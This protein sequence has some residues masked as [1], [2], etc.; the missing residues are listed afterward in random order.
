MVILTT[1]AVT[2][3]IDRWSGK[4]SRLYHLSRWN[5]LCQMTYPLLS[6][7]VM[8]VKAFFFSLSKFE[9]LTTNPGRAPNNQNPNESEE[10]LIVKSKYNWTCAS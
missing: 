8:R 7:I 3:R 2:D 9:Y 5:Q 6:C 4:G 10:R 1:N